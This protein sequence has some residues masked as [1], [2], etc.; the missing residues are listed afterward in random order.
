MN[1][2]IK[3]IQRSPTQEAKFDRRFHC[4]L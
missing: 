1:T 2:D 3:E 4:W